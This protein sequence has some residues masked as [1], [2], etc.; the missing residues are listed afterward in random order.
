MQLGARGQGHVRSLYVFTLRESGLRRQIKAAP[1]DA[2]GQT[3]A[4][5]ADTYK[6]LINHSLLAR[7]EKIEKDHYILIILYKKHACYKV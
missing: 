5:S 2:N 7:R 3:Y 6:T 1:R 4:A